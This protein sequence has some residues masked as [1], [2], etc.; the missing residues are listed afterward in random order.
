[1]MRPPTLAVLDESFTALD[2]DMVERCLIM[3]KKMTETTCVFVSHSERLEEYC[4]QI[5]VLERYGDARVL[6]PQ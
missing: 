1:M 2:S 4:D 6:L 5:V 3:L